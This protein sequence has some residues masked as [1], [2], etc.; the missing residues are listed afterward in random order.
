VAG[1]ALPA[2]SP[3]TKQYNLAVGGGGGGHAP[4]FAAGSRVGVAALP[5][6]ARGPRPALIPA[7]P[8]L[9]NRGGGLVSSGFWVRRVSV[10]GPSAH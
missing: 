5:R 3:Y 6:P 10:R 9:P 7:R 2:A 4:R 1:A 8:T